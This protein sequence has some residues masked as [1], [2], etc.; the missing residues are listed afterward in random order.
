MKQECCHTEGAR[1]V[2]RMCGIS[3]VRPL[4]PQRDGIVLNLS[5]IRPPSPRPLR[6][7]EKPLCHRATS[8]H[9]S[10]RT[11][12]LLGSAFPL[13]GKPG[14][15]G[16]FGADLG[17]HSLSEPEPW[18]RKPVLRWKPTVGRVRCWFSGP[19]WCWDCPCASPPR[20][21]L[22]RKADTRAAVAGQCG[23]G[24]ISPLWAGV[25]AEQR[26]QWLALR[27]KIRIHPHPQGQPCPTPADVPPQL[28][29][30]LVP[31]AQRLLLSSLS[32]T[33]SGGQF[34]SR[35]LFL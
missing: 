27:I 7:W 20:L 22:V 11:P 19:W 21:L 17:A 29:S 1:C 2:L 24:Q 31:Q 28:S 26:G 33:S 6:L 34:Q 32:M 18:E 5:Q 9:A 25:P 8:P 15:A 16:P 10:L 30:Y 35:G 13:T 12:A 14:S 4:L 23:L 3:R